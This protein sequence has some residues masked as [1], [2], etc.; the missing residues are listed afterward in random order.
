MSRGAYGQWD[1]ERFAPEPPKSS[2]R[3]D[4]S[5]DRARV[6]HSSALRRLGGKT[7]V[8]GAGHDD[9]SRTR[10][11]HTL[12]VAQVGRELAATLGCDPDVV[13]TACLAHDLG[14][15][16]FGH[17]GEALLAEMMAGQGGFE[18][19]AQSLR[20]LTRLEPKVL[21]ADGRSAGLNLTRASIDAS[22][23]YPWGAGERPGPK[24]GYY[25]DDLEVVRWARSEEHGRRRCLE[26]QMMDLADDIAYS[27][28][29]VEDAI[30]GGWLNPAI[31]DDPAVVDRVVAQARDWY[32]PDR[33]DTDIADALTRL[34]SLPRFVDGYDA[35]RAA[36]AGL[37]NMTSELI[38]RFAQAASELTR[39][40]YGP[41]P[42]VRY[43]AEL[44][45]P[46]QTWTE[47][48]TLKGL[49]AVFVMTKDERQGGYLEERDVLRRLV[50]GL[51]ERDGDGLEPTF[52]ADYQRASQDSE[53]LRAI[54]DQVASLTDARARAWAAH[55]SE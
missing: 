34:R 13:D 36:L 19:N 28:H 1:R 18:G 30:V 3:G 31:L 8:V 42:L 43:E 47:I 38:G 53:R 16:P 45:V 2:A 32:L 50:S 26:A 17:N 29:D 37:K 25:A 10:L 49:A 39:Q 52:A 27:V 23:K 20:L 4:F 5:R 51:I 33:S 48:G 24:F 44:A 15:P 46:E 14:H 22:I 12:E 40:R 55:V 54:V 7:Q 6:L 9:F 41:G 35:S 11:T 21:L